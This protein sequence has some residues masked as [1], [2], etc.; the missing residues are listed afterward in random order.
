VTAASTIDEYLAALPAADRAALEAVRATIRSVAP[1]ME[2]RMSS[3]APFF[4]HEGQRAIGFGAARHHL[5]LYIMHGAVLATHRAML[6]GYDTSR[7]VVRFTRACPLPEALVRTLVR[8]RLREIR[9]GRV[10][11][12]D[13]AA[14][15]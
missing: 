3:G 4:W 15:S 12:A 14:T 13:H 7:T 11:A 5:S 2:E 9:L 6:E 8:A 1:D 10:A